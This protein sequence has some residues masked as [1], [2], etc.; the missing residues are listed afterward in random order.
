MRLLGSAFAKTRPG[1][2]V[3]VLPSL[4]S[5]GGIRALLADKIDIAVST[6]PVKDPGGQLVAWDYART[7][8]VFA[9]HHDTPVGGITRHEL[10]Q[11]YAGS[12]TA[13]PDG[14]RL[15]VVLRPVVEYDMG[16]VRALSP[17]MDNA[18][19]AATGRDLLVATTDQDNAAALEEIRGS[20]GM[21]SLGQMLTEGRRLKPLALDG[22]E[23]TVDALRA[24]RYP[25]AKTL[26]L[27]TKPQPSPLAEAF[28]RF[29]RSVEGL[30][31]LAASGHLVTEG[32]ARPGM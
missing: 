23:G 26:A 10:A 17:E 15:R 13:W 9:T 14:T 20:L 1:V 31:I 24:G 32:N 11:A 4:G 8:L 19:E 2:E 16:V 28:L 29:V 7:P 3:V 27:V 22:I 5:S 30:R 12:L 25:H 21:I 18:V 6:S